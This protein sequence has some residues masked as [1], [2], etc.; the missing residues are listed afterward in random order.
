MDKVIT[1]LKFRCCLQSFHPSTQM[2]KI[3]HQKSSLL[4]NMTVY[5]EEYSLLNRP[6]QTALIVSVTRFVQYLVIFP[7]ATE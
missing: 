6:G 2:I 3:Q 4:A 5:W 1:K 7:I